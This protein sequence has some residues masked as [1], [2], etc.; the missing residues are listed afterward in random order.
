MSLEPEMV[1]IRYVRGVL[2]TTAGEQQRLILKKA[3]LA[4]DIF[5]KGTGRITAAQY[6][7]LLQ[8]LWKITFD[9]SLGFTETP[10]K[11]GTF[12]MMCH[13]ICHCTHLEHALRRMG[14]F[15]RLVTDDFRLLVLRCHDSLRLELHIL[16]SLQGAASFFIESIFAV[17]LRLSAWLIDHPIVPVRLGFA[18]QES[19]ISPSFL[20]RSRAT[21]L[22]E[23]E[24]SFLEL[25]LQVAQEPLRRGPGDLKGLLADAPLSFLADFKGEASYAAQLRQRW[26]YEAESLSLGLE[27]FARDFGL[28][29]ASLRRKLRG[30]GASFHELRDE[31]RRK[32]ACHLL[33]KTQKSIDTIASTLGYSES[34]TFHRAFKKWTGL[35]PSRFREGAQDG[36]L[37]PVGTVSSPG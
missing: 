19:Q 35:S 12:A 1:A 22:Y 18:F 27:S 28:S 34:S 10:L 21:V 32:R 15:Y 24:V 29:P 16:R 36:R 13:A 14:K 17:L 20:T 30:E 5:E 26:S 7:R 23:N 6:S 33:L 4:E 8:I 25:P 3:G 31:F 2:S 37:A 9:E 11:P